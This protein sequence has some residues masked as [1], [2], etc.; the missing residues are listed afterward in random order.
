VPLREDRVIGQALLPTFQ[1]D[2]KAHRGTAARD[3]VTGRETLSSDSGRLGV[4]CQ[5]PVCGEL[6]TAGLLKKGLSAFRQR[7]GQNDAGAS[8]A[9]AT[10]ADGRLRVGL[11]YSSRVGF[12]NSP[13]ATYYETMSRRDIDDR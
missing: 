8:D 6:G 3:P 7:N 12:F 2:V 11:R 4:G 5:V 13:T 1:I 10:V 9:T